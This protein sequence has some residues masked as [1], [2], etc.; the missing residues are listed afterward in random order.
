MRVGV[1]IHIDPG[2]HVYWLN[3]GDAGLATD[4]RL[5]LPDGWSAGPLAWPAPKRFEQPGGIVGF[6]YE[7]EVVLAREVQVPSDARG[8]VRIPVTAS[9]LA[10]REVC[11][12]GEAHLEATIPAPASDAESGRR[13]LDDWSHRLPTCDGTSAPWD[14]TVRRSDEGGAMAIW[15]R[16]TTPVRSVTWFPEALAAAKLGGGEAKTRGNLTRIDLTL[17]PIAGRVLPTKLPSVITWTDD[18]GD[19]HARCFDVEIAAG[20]FN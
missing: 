13:L 3:P 2:W 15:L 7:D 1:R 6:G 9:W 17:R 20:T 4:V 12:L 18:Q 11:V 16:W 19:R 14:A 8:P 5:E 10:C